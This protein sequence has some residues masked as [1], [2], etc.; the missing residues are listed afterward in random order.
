MREDKPLLLL[1][2]K[3]RIKTID[4]KPPRMPRFSES[5]PQS[6]IP[7]KRNPDSAL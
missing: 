5:V 2:K 6:T 1:D 4:N 7:T 3:K